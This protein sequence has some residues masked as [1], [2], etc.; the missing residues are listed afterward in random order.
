MATTPWPPAA[1]MEMSPRLPGPASCSVLASWATIRPPV[2]A[3]GCP[4]ASDEP[5]T[6]SFD[7]VDRAERGVE[8]ELLLAEVR[9][10]PGLQRGEHRGG[11]GL[12]DLVEVEVLQ[13]QAVAGQ[14][15]RHRRR[16]GPSAGPRRR[17]RSRPPRS[18]RRPGGRAPAARGP[19]AHSSEASR[20]AEAP[21]VSGVEL[22][23]VIVAPSP[24]PNTGLSVDELLQRR[25]RPQVVVAG[26][27]QERR[28]QVVEEAAVVGGGHVLVRADGELVLLLAADLPLLGGDRGVVAHRQAGARLGV[29]RDLRHELARAGSS[30]AP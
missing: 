11:E 22:P 25:V 9:V 27:A 5:L 19:P 2:A 4:A 21:S 8:A 20:T 28:H 7:A 17:A 18:A 13:A 29:A 23:A 26:E 10:L 3:N 1:Q 16:P 24:L 30:P 14:Q 15:H 6:L 12:V